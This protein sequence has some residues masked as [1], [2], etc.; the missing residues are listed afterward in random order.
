MIADESNTLFVY[1]VTTPNEAWAVGNVYDIYGM[2]DFYF[3]PWQLSSNADK[4]L[5]L[6]PSTPPRP[7]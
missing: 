2:V 4:P 1:T 6:V 3:S 7:C 5:V